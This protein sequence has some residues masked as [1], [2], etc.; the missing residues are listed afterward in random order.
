MLILE[1]SLGKVIVGVVQNICVST[2][3]WCNGPC[4]YRIWHRCILE[5]NQSLDKVAYYAI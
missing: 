1:L 3:E 5:V 2:V 4:R